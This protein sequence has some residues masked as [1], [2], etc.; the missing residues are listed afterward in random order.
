MI[1]KYFLISL[2]LA[3]LQIQAQ[4]KIIEVGNTVSTYIKI[5]DVQNVGS[6]TEISLE[7]APT[8]AV[9][10]TLHSP[11]GKSP[12][13]LSDQRGNRYALKSQM[14]WEGPDT[15]GYGTLQLLANQKKY[16][17]LFFNKLDNLDEIY[18]LTELGC[19][20]NGCWNF[21]DIKL[22][23]KISEKKKPVQAAYMKTWVDYNVKNDA[24]E[25]GMRIHVKFSVYNL[26]DGDCYLLVRFMNEKDEFL[27][28]EKVEYASK[29][30]QISLYKKLKPIYDQ[31]TFNDVKVFMPYAELNL[32]KADHNLKYDLDLIY[33]NGELIKHFHIEKFSY[34]N[35]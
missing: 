3:S 35:N 27:K 6:W 19:T 14:G 5:V 25:L 32:P 9:N 23:D 22:K 21:Y 16:V 4:Q 8:S 24:G 34:K 7:L 15:G 13:V 17:K 31:T 1:K 18:S 26:K 33:Q 12:Y 30:G 11:S 28:T 2:V 10:A 29:S 20:G